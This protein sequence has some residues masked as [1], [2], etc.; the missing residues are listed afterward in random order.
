MIL[1]ILKEDPKIVVALAADYGNMG[2]VAITKAQFT[3]IKDTYTDH[4]IV[5]LYLSDINKKLIPLKKVISPKDIITIIGGG[6]MGDQ[7]EL[8]EE[9]RRNIIKFFPKNKIISFPQTIDFNI[10]HEGK[11]ALNRSINIY[12]KHRNLHIFAREPHSFNMM[13]EIFKGNYVYMVP[14]IV[15]Y[16]N[17]VEPELNRDGIILSLRNDS[18]KKISNAQREQLVSLIIEQYDNVEFLDTHVGDDNYAKEKADTELDKMWNSFKKSKVVVTDR[19]HG[20]IFCAITKTP[21]VV[22]PNSNHKIAGTY[23]KWLSDLEYIEFVKEYDEKIVLDFIYKY[24]S[25][26]IDKYK[27]ANLRDQF[28]ALS[29]VL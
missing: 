18:E 23:Y 13:K 24:Y 12:S 25:I 1:P 3:F 22:L 16:L 7:Y 6:N 26:D 29:N 15:L 9:H 20:M 21:C 5:P 14:D 8:F 28:G 19:L 4:K 11:K 2:D 17:K 10:S 27:P